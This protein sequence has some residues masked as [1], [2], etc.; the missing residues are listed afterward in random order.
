MNSQ[1]LLS[2][3]IYNTDYLHFQ[4][5]QNSQ[6]P[7]Q[8]AYNQ[9]PNDSIFYSPPTRPLTNFDPRNQSQ[10]QNRRQGVPTLQINPNLISPP[11][12]AFSTNTS[13]S[14]YHAPDTP[15]AMEFGDA[16]SIRNGREA[17]STKGHCRTDTQA[18]FNRFSIMLKKDASTS[19]KE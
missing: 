19:E 3:E 17:G 8:L 6:F 14:S 9:P 18:V 5:S 2:L 10:N 7:S 11:K 1:P 16:A 12:A 15:R 13:P 4:S